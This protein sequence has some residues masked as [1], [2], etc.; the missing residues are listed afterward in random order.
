M[1]PDI[2]SNPSWKFTKWAAGCVA[3][4]LVT[5]VAIENRYAKSQDIVAV[6]GDV[7]M[8]KSEAKAEN[9][10]VE[11]RIEQKFHGT[12]LKIDRVAS[13]MRVSSLSDK[14]AE[15]K[16]RSAVS[17][18]PEERA[19]LGALIAQKEQ[20]LAAASSSL[21]TIETAMRASGTQ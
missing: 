16:L 2:E 14:I 8:F 12:N 15:Y 21:L 13:S 5:F 10:R 19:L 20:E 9:S 6:K 4:I 11:G 7:S 17:K 18:S 1:E 3:A